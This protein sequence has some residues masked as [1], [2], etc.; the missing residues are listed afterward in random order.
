[1]SRWFWYFLIYGFLGYCLEKIFARTVKSPQQVRKCFLLLPIC[2]VYGLAMCLVVAAAPE[3]ILAGAVTGGIICTGAEY[4][5]H[6][7]YD[8]LFQVRFWDY[9]RLPGNLQGRICPQFSLIWGLLSSLAL[10]WLQPGVRAAAEGMPPWLTYGVWLLLA[11]D[12][13]C[14]AALLS[15]W[16]DPE[17]LV[18]GTVIRQARASSQSSTSR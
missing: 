15:R 3:G 16:G 4:V 5:V 18:L 10:K 2:P 12:C 7:W 6:L 11:A 13:V 14:T 8:R 17:Q 9:S 1:M